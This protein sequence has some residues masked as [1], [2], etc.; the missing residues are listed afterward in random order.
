M[1]HKQKPKKHQYPAKAQRSKV[2]TPRVL[3]G[4]RHIQKGDFSI[5]DAAGD[6]FEWMEDL[7]P[8]AKPGWNIQLTACKNLDPIFGTEVD[9]PDNSTWL[10]V[11]VNAYPECNRIDS[12]LVVDIDAEDHMESCVYK[13][14]SDEEATLLALVK[15]AAVVARCADY[16]SAWGFTSENA[17]IQE[18]KRPNCH[19][20][21]PEMSITGLSAKHRHIL[22]RKLAVQGKMPAFPFQIVFHGHIARNQ[23]DSLWYGG[24]IAEVQYRG[25]RFIL[26]A[27]G[28][29]FATLSDKADPDH[30][31]FYVK[32]KNNRGILGTELQ[33]YIANDKA[34][35]AARLGHHTKYR[36]EMDSGNWWE[37][38]PVSE[39]GK[40][41]DIM[42]ALESDS[43]LDALPEIIGSM[44]DIVQQL[45]PG[46]D[47]GTTV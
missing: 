46:Q 20:E 4:T 2:Y 28:D 44:D 22:R 15:E 39:D 1:K 11:Y 5:P 23:Y 27:C 13:L 10:N 43:V 9:T 19:S 35:L 24:D 41:H 18:V 6:A 40:F 7:L 26:S 14:R 37:C 31:L 36:L 8:G 25:W 47:E 30:E 32:D 3:V 38:F 21:L 29:I 33:H 12:N 34:L 45:C 16:L 42:W 17:E